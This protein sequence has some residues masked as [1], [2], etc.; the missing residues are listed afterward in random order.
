M[1]RLEKL[2]MLIWDK[3]AESF[4]DAE[5]EELLNDANNDVYAA[6]AACLNLVRSNP[7][8]YTSYS[9]G[10]LS[11]TYQDLDKAIKNYQSM[12]GVAFGTTESKRTY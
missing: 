4:T 7:N 1:G 12:A 10:P 9:I 2:R 5:L 3:D 6:A 8:R 11:F